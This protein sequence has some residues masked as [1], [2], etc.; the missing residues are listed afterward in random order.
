ME[1]EEKELVSLDKET[2]FV[3]SFF[4]LYHEREEGKIYL[5]IN[6][7]DAEDYLIIPVSL[8]SLLENAIKHNAASC[9]RPLKINIR[10]ENGWLVMSNN[11]QKRNIMGNSLGLGLEN[12]KERFKI[13]TGRDMVITDNDNYYTVR[14]PLIK[15][16]DA[17]TDN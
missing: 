11:I 13:I 1:N 2:D 6:V 4:M 3:R 15:E 14:I 12:L 16:K 9:D 17:S 8:Q 7:D 5:D 10:K